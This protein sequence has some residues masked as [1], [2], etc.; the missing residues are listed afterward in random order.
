MNEHY[1]GRIK[2]QVDALTNFL[3]CLVFY[4]LVYIIF[5]IIR[6][7]EQKFWTSFITLVPF[8]F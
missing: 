1:S 7:L 6:L 4:H 8:I 2:N 5:F 3:F